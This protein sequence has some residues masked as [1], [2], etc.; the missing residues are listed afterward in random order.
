M[1]QRRSL[2]ARKLVA[3]QTAARRKRVP[4]RSRLS[5]PF[6][7]PTSPRATAV[8]T[9]GKVETSKAE[10]MGSQMEIQQALVEMARDRSGEG[11]S[12][13]GNETVKSDPLVIKLVTEDPEIV[14]VWLV[15]QNGG[16]Q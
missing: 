6:K 4:E 3:S 5:R 12:N 1:A 11:E 2:S 14:I 7:A 10:V 16:K 9:S 15:D 13:A 8:A